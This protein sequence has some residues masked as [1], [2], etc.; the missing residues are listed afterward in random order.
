LNFT[1]VFV[2]DSNAVSGMNSILYTSLL[3]YDTVLD[4][5]SC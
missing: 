5:T 3:F 1:E 2:P 4:Y